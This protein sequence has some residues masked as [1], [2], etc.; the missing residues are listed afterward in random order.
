MGL[1]IY[2]AARPG[3]SHSDPTSSALMIVAPVGTI[4]IV[5]RLCVFQFP[6]FDLYITIL[7]HKRLSVLIK[8]SRLLYD[9]YRPYSSTLISELFNCSM[10]PLRA[11]ESLSNYLT[12]HQ[13]LSTPSSGDWLPWSAR[14]SSRPIF[15]VMDAV[16]HRRVRWSS[17]WHCNLRHSHDA[18]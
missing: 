1:G 17:S 14:I 13:Q 7:T 9:I 5:L 16:L 10:L 15:P 2:A 12:S 8:N 11:W 4:L 18:M 6:S 3:E